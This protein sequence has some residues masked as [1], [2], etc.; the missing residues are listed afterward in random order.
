MCTNRFVKGCGCA[1][2]EAEF[3]QERA[4]IAAACK[5]EWQILDALAGRREATTPAAARFVACLRADPSADGGA[6]VHDVLVSNRRIWWWDR[7]GA[8]HAAPAAPALALAA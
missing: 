2:S 8:Q 7:S 5:I 1:R 4:R 6:A 3:R